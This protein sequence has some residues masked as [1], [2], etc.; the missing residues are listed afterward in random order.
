MQRMYD[1]LCTLTVDQAT[2]EIAA[3]TDDAIASFWAWN[4]SEAASY[5]PDID[6]DGERAEI[7]ASLR[8]NLINDVS[9]EIR[10]RAGA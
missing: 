8:D 10:F 4:D 2:A 5:L 3:M 9:A 6:D 1:R 7:V